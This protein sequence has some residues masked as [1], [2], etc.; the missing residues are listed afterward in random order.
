M[1]RAQV[2]APGSQASNGT[3]PVWLNHQAILVGSFVALCTVSFILIY[4]LVPETKL[5]TT[6]EDKKRTLNYISLEELNQIFAIRTRDCINYYINHVA[7]R[8]LNN[9]LYYLRLRSEWKDI[10]HSMHFW[11]EDPM[12][13]H[14]KP[15]E[16]GNESES[17]TVQENQHDGDGGH[18]TAEAVH[19]ENSPAA[20]TAGRSSDDQITRATP[21]SHVLPMPNTGASIDFGSGSYPDG[22]PVD[23]YR[24]YSGGERG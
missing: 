19:D 21:A 15:N 9:M 16:N 18:S 13:R 2:S 22:R 6:T 23:L 10:Q 5:A 20:A 3:D 7:A 8:R 17:T 12:K 14:R 4:F 1:P 11:A 24:R